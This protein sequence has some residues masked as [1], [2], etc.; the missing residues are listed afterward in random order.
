MTLGDF[1]HRKLSG[2]ALSAPA[3]LALAHGL[4]LIL[5][6]YL[7]RN[8]THQLIQSIEDYLRTDDFSSAVSKMVGEP[9]PDETEDEFVSRAKTAIQEILTERFNEDA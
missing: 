8:D 5:S 7:G 1:I 6:R 9:T 3:H 2:G 4:P